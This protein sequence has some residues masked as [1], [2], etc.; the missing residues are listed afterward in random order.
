M[1][2][3]VA[4]ATLWRWARR[5]VALRGGGRVHLEVCRAGCRTLTSE[6]AL[7]RFLAAQERGDDPA[8]EA[9]STAPK[10]KQRQAEIAAAQAELARRKI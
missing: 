8:R 6:Q 4:A 1:N 5:G 9:E 7:R 3:P 2:R 10:P